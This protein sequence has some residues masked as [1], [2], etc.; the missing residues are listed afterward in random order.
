MKAPALPAGTFGPWA[1]GGGGYATRGPTS[2]RE[3][4]GCSLTPAEH[5]LCRC[6]LCPPR[7]LSVSAPR[8]GPLLRGQHTSRFGQDH[9][10]EAPAVG[11]AAAVDVVLEVVALLRGE[12]DRAFLGELVEPGMVEYLVTFMFKHI[13]GPSAE[14]VRE[15]QEE[16]QRLYGKLASWVAR[17]PKSPEFSHLL[18][19]GVFFPDVPG[20]KK[21]SKS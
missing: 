8:R 21:A 20:L 14:K 2:M 13:S 6:Q 5:L 10:R 11:D 1:Q 17:K 3:V 15:M 4:V 19:R 18:P 12:F 7:F 9:P 16:V